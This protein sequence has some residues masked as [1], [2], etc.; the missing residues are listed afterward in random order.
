MNK[1]KNQEDLK[2][3]LQGIDKEYNLALARL[4]KVHQDFLNFIKERENKKV[5]K[6]IS[7]LRKN[8]LNK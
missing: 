2:K 5:Q 6:R 4:N 1:N 7:K 8:I 3:S